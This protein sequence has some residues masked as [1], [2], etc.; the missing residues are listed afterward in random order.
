MDERTIVCSNCNQVMLPVDLQQV[1][2]GDI[3]DFVSKPGNKLD[4]NWYWCSNCD[5][6]E[7]YTTHERLSPES[8]RLVETLESN[9]SAW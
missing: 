3:K 9:L 4:D 5:M 1:P 8:E 2:A 7:Q 6:Y